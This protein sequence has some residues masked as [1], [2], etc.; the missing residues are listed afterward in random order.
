MR[1][2]KHFLLHNLISL[3]IMILIT[4][5][6]RNNILYLIKK[7]TYLLFFIYINILFNFFEQKH[8]FL[9][10]FSEAEYYVF[11]GIRFIII[12]F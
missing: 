11:R 2:Y 12:E 1:F 10:Q 3:P 4:I 7:S 5:Y 6:N 8:T 9:I